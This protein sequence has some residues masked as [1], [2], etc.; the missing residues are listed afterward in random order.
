M[1][2]RNLL[3]FFFLTIAAITYGQNEFTAIVLDSFTN[4]PL[5]GATTVLKGTT[6]GASSDLNGNV[7]VFNIPNG[8]QVIMVSFIGYETIELSFR[9]P[10]NQRQPE[11]ILRSL[12]QRP[13]QCG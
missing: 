8:E 6:I 11:K 3:S 10:L 12:S 1:I 9:F 13:V 2:K 5:V 4:D 7:T